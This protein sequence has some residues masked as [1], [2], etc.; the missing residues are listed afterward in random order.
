MI[1]CLVY[2]ITK[3][4]SPSS[5]ESPRAPLLFVAVSQ[6]A[7]SVLNLSAWLAVIQGNHGGTSLMPSGA[8][9]PKHYMEMHIISP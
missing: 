2:N 5:K 3:R 6:S 7:E 9:V 4:F 8:G 1:L